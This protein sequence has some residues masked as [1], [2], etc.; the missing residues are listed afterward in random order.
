MTQ[1][2]SW[3][4]W[5]ACTGIALL[6]SL[7]VGCDGTTG[8]RRSSFALYAGGIARPDSGPLVFDNALGF[9]ITLQTAR[10][11]VGPVYWNVAPP[12]T[13]NR[14]SLWQRARSWP[15]AALIG[16]ARADET[17]DHLGGGRII[18]QV[19]ARAIVNTLSPELTLLG[20]GDG[21]S[22]HAQTA[23][24]WLLPED[25][26]KQSGTLPGSAVAQLEGQAERSGMTIPFTALLPL[27]AQMAGAEPLQQLRSVRRVPANI[28]FGA[29]GT[30]PDLELRI[31]P[32]PWLNYADF[33]DLAARPLEGSTHPVLHDDQVMR[34]L[35]A[36]VRQSQGVYFFA[37]RKR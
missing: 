10:I 27:D 34:V 21:V 1:Q 13:L 20:L 22:E 16:T 23:E 7:S 36:G 6:C 24:L 37:V 26:A 12:L 15:L 4:A 31:D 2:S 5:I 19:T 8:L 3:P 29:E 32:R 35:Q 9:H 28:D 14:P 30:N 17:Q 33:S 11:A 25:A 18:A